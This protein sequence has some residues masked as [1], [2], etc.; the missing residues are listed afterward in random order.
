MFTPEG[1]VSVAIDKDTG[2]LAT[3]S[4]PRVYTEVFLAG[5]EPRETCQT[6]GS[7]SFFSRVGAF[8]G[9]GR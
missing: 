1:V 4:C 2:Q 9:F 3:D 8:F 5:H 7:R 6:H